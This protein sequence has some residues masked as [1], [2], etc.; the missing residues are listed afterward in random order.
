MVRSLF[1]ISIIVSAYIFA[2]YVPVF[3]SIAM[4]VY[5]N[6]PEIIVGGIILD[7]LYATQLDSFLGSTFI[8][9]VLFLVLYSASIIIKSQLINYA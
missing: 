6:A 2:W 4:L 7:A 1:I 3:L 9:T 8:F 5:K